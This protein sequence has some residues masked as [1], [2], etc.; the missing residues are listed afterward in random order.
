MRARKD[1]HRESLCYAVIRRSAVVD[2]VPR[3]MSATCALFLR[4]NHLRLVLEYRAVTKNVGRARV[5]NVRVGG[6]CHV[7][8]LRQS[9]DIINK[10]GTVKILCEMK[11][12]Q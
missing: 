4:R 5:R 8:F 1:K 2:H 12:R 10:A 11:I 7:Y 9:T 3:K 6:I